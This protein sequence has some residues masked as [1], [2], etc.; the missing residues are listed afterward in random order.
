MIACTL[1]EN[2]GRFLYRSKPTHAK[3]ARQLEILMRLKESKVQDQNLEYLIDNAFYQCVPQTT[4]GIKRKERTPM[5]LYIRHLI[6][7]RLAPV[8]DRSSRKDKQ[9]KQR[10]L[11]N[12]VVKLIEK[13]NL[14]DEVTQNML[15]KSFLSITK[16]K[17]GSIK[18]VCSVL[19]TLRSHKFDFITCRV[20][21]GLLEL[22]RAGLDVSDF[23]HNQRRVGQMKFLGE[24]CVARLVNMNLIFETLYML[25]E[26][27]HPFPAPEKTDDDDEVLPLRPLR[28]GEPRSVRSHPSVLCKADMPHD[29]LRI[30]LIC[31]L[32]DTVSHVLKR[33]KLYKKRLDTFLIYFDRYISFKWSLTL[34]V[35]FMIENTI[36]DLRPGRE[37]PKPS[38]VNETEKC[39]EEYEKSLNYDVHNADTVRFAQDVDEEEEEEELEDMDDEEQ[40]EDKV[41]EKQ[42]SEEQSVHILREERTE[43]ADPEFEKQFRAMMKSSSSTNNLSDRNF[44]KLSIPV[45]LLGERTK[46]EKNTT[47][48][49][50]NRGVT[51]KLLNRRGGKVA[52]KTLVIPERVSLS[53]YAKV[54]RDAERKERDAF[55]KRILEGAERQEMDGDEDASPLVKIQQP[56]IF[57][58]RKKY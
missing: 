2:C 43:E 24:L 13:L 45:S 37:I 25:I 22:I 36:E 41:E 6:L 48:P 27:G 4:R 30:R 51:F 9:R 46:A 40:T 17:F 14:Q 49:T 29:V 52:A 32:L 39:V 16:G 38:L 11:L 1:L 7:N 31:V 56:V 54:S 57:R 47:Q 15:V 58:K 23:R 50:R 44:D 55:A 19:R 33:S 21:D 8:Q 53:Q 28:Q 34:D 20:I 26:I 12:R 42:D 35:R 18:N 5:Y 10:A 3:C